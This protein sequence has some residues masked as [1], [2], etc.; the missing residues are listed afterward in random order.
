MNQKTKSKTEK[1]GKKHHNSTN[2]WNKKEKRIERE[3][4]EL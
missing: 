1:K 2:I 3:T 4:Y